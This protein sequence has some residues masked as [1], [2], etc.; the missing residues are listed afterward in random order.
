MLGY[1][2]ENRNNTL[3]SVIKIADCLGRSLRE[4]VQLFS[5][6]SENKKCSFVTE[7]GFVVD[8]NYSIKKSNIVLENMRVQDS[9]IFSDNDHFNEF[10]SG[11]IRN[12][13]SNIHKS[14]YPDANSSFDEILDLWETRLRFN[15]VKKRLEERS[16]AFSNTQDIIDTPEFQKFLEVAPQVI[17]W[18]TNNR[19]EITSI[20]EIKNAVKLSNSVSLA[21]DLPKIPITKL[22][23]QS[24]ITFTNNTPDSIYDIICKQELVAK[25]LK[26]SKQN[27]DLIWANNKNINSLA[28]LLYSGNEEKIAE[29]FSESLCDVPYVALASKKQLTETFTK[30]L[31]LESTPEIDF[32]EKDIKSFA[33]IIFEMKKPVKE[34]LINTINEKYG[35]NVQNLKEV[36]SFRG[37]VEAQIVIFESLSRLAPKSSVMKD[38]LSQVSKM[39]KEKSGVEAIDVNDI[40]QIIFERANYT[41]L[42]ENYSIAEKLTLKDIVEND[43]SPSEIVSLIES[44]TQIKTIHDKIKKLEE[45]KENKKRKDEENGNGGNGKG[46]GKSTPHDKVPEVYEPKDK[47]KKKED[48]PD[49]PEDVQSALSGEDKNTH[50]QYAE[51]KEEESEEKS[52]DDS[53][54]KISKEDF[55]ANLDALTNLLSGEEDNTEASTEK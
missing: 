34:L 39:L 13:V 33:S 30:T 28:S 45:F 18:L 2:F 41:S 5:I 52:K 10:V 37:L 36:A 53:K 44:Q 19:E 32:S 22:E 43:L 14:D 15:E 20:S 35:V 6:D 11:R 27:F 26:E 31:Q 40:L 8:G 7:S 12:F 46:N 29:I 1:M 3:K 42:C 9:E 17:S 25:E 49:T 47:K 21:F 16:H 24:K 4:N 50:S 54:K 51:A 55:F 23:E 38:V 48:N